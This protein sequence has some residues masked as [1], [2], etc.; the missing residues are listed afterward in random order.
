MTRL[1]LLISGVLIVLALALVSRVLGSDSAWNDISRV[2]TVLSALLA[3]GALGAFFVA[4]GR[5]VS[6]AVVRAPMKRAWRAN[7]GGSSSKVRD[8]MI[9]AVLTESETSTPRAGRLLARLVMIESSHAHREWPWASTRQRPRTWF[10]D[11]ARRLSNG[12]APRIFA[13]D[14][15]AAV[16]RLAEAAGRAEEDLLFYRVMDRELLGR[17]VVTAAGVR[18]PLFRDV[19]TILSGALV[20]ADGVQTRSGAL[21]R[22]RLWHSLANP[23]T[24]QTFGQTHALGPRRL[25]ERLEACP[26]GTALAGQD[27]TRAGDFDGRVI[28]LQGVALVQ[29]E[30]F[31]GVDVLLRTGET[32]Y[33]ATEAARDVINGRGDV[34]CKGLDTIAAATRRPTWHLDPQSTS[35]SRDAPEETRLCLLT[36]FTSLVINYRVGGAPRS[37]FI[38]TQRSGVTR[39][40]A[41]LLSVAGGGVVNLPIGNWP[42]DEDEH[43]FPDLVGGVR[44]ELEEELGLELSADRFVPR[45]IMV[46][47]QH[48]PI[49]AGSPTIPGVG[50]GELV[51]T[52][53]FIATIDLDFAELKARRMHASPSKGRYESADLVEIP[54]PPVTDELSPVEAAAR[55]AAELVDGHGQRIDQRSYLAGLYLAADVYGPEA[56]IAA[57]RTRLWWGLP[58]HPDLQPAA[59]TVPRLFVPP[60]DLVDTDSV[61]RLR[62]LAADLGVDLAAWAARAG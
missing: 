29:D 51:A 49:S 42:G 3:L 53:D 9:D 2:E 26:W 28:D 31:E 17:K 6:R 13:P 39:N 1:L 37:S 50:R 60:T 11:L 25:E 5:W 48:G 36:A 52:A 10:Q 34:R 56:A 12:L 20:L 40:G 61:E 59:T 62:R 54:I 4:G 19:A 27:R 30:R 23:H 15:A 43:G 46:M 38:L 44:R 55:F 24:E 32:C 35:A 22:V 16:G 14:T 21:H 33:A 7:G 57:F 45:A 41:G 8:E 18:G 58:W 47:S